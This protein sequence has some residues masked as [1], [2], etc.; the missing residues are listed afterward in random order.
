[1]KLGIYIPS[2]GRADKLAALAEN[3]KT[4]T[5]GDFQ[6]YWG[7]EKR[8]K[9]SIKAAEKTGYPIIFNTGESKYSDALQAIYE[10]TDEEIF[11]WGNDDFYFLPS[12]NEGPLRVME[13]NPKIGVLGVHDGN[14]KTRYNTISFVRRSY[15]KE[16]SGVIGIPNRVL[17]PYLHN[18]VDDELTGTAQARGVW[19]KY[20]GPCIEHR[21]HSFTWLK[22]T[23]P[24]DGTYRKNDSGFARDTET[25]YARRHLWV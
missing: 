1:M 19:D 5:E 2:Y 14:P 6:L 7:L 18:Y 25:F 4:A 12:W 10:N 22:D 23:L 3:I 11:F 15:I 16:Q 17:Y 9:E 13:I 21:H 20:E 24:M 8:D